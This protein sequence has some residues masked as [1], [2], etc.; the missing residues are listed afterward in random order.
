MNSPQRKSTLLSTSL[1]TLSDDELNLRLS[2][3]KS[4]K[5]RRLTE[6]KLSFYEPYPKQLAFHA[7]GKTK[8]ERLFLAGNQANGKSFCSAMEAALHA[9]GLYDSLSFEWPGYRFDRPTHGWCCGASNTVLRDTIQKLLLGNVGEF[10]TG[11]IPKSHLIGTTTA[12]GVAELIDTIRVR[13]VSGGV[14]TIALKSYEAGR[15]HLQGSTL[16]WAS[17]DEQVDDSVYSEIMTRSMLAQGPVWTVFT[18]LMGVD[19]LVRRFMYEPSDSR[20]LITATIDDSPMFDE[21]QKKVI[22]EGWPEHERECRARGVPTVGIGKIFPLARSQISCDRRSIPEH[23]P[24]I[25]AMDMGYLNFAAVTLAHD[26]DHDCVYLTRAIK[27]K[28]ETPIIHAS[29]L[30]R[31]GKELR[32]AWPSDARNRTSAGAGVPLKEQYAAEGLNML[33]EHAQF[34]DK[35]T[36]VEAGL[37]NWL[38]RMKT[39]RFKVFDDLE[40]FWQEFHLYHRDE[41]GKVVKDHDHILDACRYGLM[42]LR[43]AQT[44]VGYSSFNR[45]IVYPKGYSGC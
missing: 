25:G 13:H 10:G 12:R 16:D 31:W 28:E 6:D 27:M 21:E 37:N 43:H 42:M 18:P 45:E 3:L 1:P 22:I 14:S 17:C 32:W 4:E 7:A 35:T 30:R 36:S 8:R 39:G 41:K 24:Q 33:W 11:A 5:E 34:E 20:A 26:R 44:K 23:W 15:D 29:V 19:S 38:D 40:D 9:T 2:L